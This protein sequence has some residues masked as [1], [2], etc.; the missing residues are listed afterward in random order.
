[1]ESLATQLRQTA[2]ILF[3][4]GYSKQDYEKVRE[5]TMV[6]GMQML[7]GIEDAELLGRFIDL[8]DTAK[9]QAANGDWEIATPRILALLVRLREAE[10]RWSPQ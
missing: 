1:M 3:E 4:Q 8:L 7:E 10:R 6:L 5:A 9:R 2:E